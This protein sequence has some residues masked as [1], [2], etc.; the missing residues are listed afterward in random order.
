MERILCIFR[1]VS[2]GPVH[3]EIGEKC[4]RFLSV[5]TNKKRKKMQID[6]TWSSIK[7]MIIT[8]SIIACY[9]IQLIEFV[10]KCIQSVRITRST[11][12]YCLL[13]EWRRNIFISLKACLW[14]QDKNNNT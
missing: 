12:L 8:P 13:Q 2:F 7:G 6:E 14:E 3:S 4:V 5:E 10:D 9:L 11:R 1:I